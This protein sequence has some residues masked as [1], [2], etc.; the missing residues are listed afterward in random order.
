MEMNVDRAYPDEQLGSEG[1]RRPEARGWSLGE[2]VMMGRPVVGE[3][4]VTGPEERKDRGTYLSEY[5]MFTVLRTEMA[6]LAGID[7]ADETARALESTGVEVRGY[8]DLGGFNGDADLLVWLHSAE[9][10][11][12][13]LAYHALLGGSLGIS[14]RPV[15]SVVV[16]GGRETG[17]GEP[18]APTNKGWV[19]YGEQGPLPIKKPTDRVAD[20][21]GLMVP[22]RGASCFAGQAM[23]TQC[24]VLLAEADSPEAVSAAMGWLNQL[25]LLLGV[26]V[27]YRIGRRVDLASWVARQPQAG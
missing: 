26:A 24:A 21:P 23:G 4:P 8:F 19:A 14:M 3:Y 10:G 9:P 15:S 5:T 2:A 11:R 13:Q 12:L 6:F 25:M 17:S 22:M 27:D 18:G 20:N 16:F 7:V 1:A